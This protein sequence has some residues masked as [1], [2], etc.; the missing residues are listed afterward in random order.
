[1][2]PPHGLFLALRKSL[3]RSLVFSSVMVVAGLPLRGLSITRVVISC[4]FL[5]FLLIFKN[6]ALQNT[7]L[8]IFVD[9]TSK[10]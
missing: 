6:N 7:L 9:F 5:R 8:K 2:Q 1:M 10:K 4:L 3:P